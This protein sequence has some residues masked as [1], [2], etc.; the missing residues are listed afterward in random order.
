MLR[1]NNSNCNSSN[2]KYNSKCRQKTKS[3]DSDRN[4]ESSKVCWLNKRNYKWLKSKKR[5]KTHFKHFWTNWSSVKMRN[6]SSLTV[7]AECGKSSGARDRYC[8]RRRKR[9]KKRSPQMRNKYSKSHRTDSSSQ[10]AY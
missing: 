4:S 2:T 3:S 7:K 8:R 6:E 5:L 1:S 10:T 9:K